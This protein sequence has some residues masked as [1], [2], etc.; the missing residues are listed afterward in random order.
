MKKLVCLTMAILMLLGMMAGCGNNA[1]TTTTPPAT[2]PPATPPPTDAP[3][4]PPATEEPTPTVANPADKF[5]DKNLN[6]AIFKGGFGDAYWNDM[7]AQFEAAYPGVKVNMT[8]DADIGNLLAPQIAVGEWPDFI[9]LNDTER[10]GVVASMVKNKQLLDLTDVFN[11][12]ALDKPGTKLSDTIMPGILDSTKCAV[13]GDGKI[14]IAPF[15]CSP[16][17]LV[18]NKALFA[19]KGWKVPSTWDEFFALNEELKKPE[20]FV[21]VDGKQVQRA[22]LTYQGIYAGY[23]ESFFWPAVA[24]AA[25]M[26]ALKNIGAYKEGSMTNP[27]VMKV[28]E[29]FAKIGTGYLM[30]GTTALDHTQSQTDMML[31]KALFIPD[32][33]WLEGEMKDAP[34][35]AGLE[36]G[37]MPAPVLTAGQEH[38][39]LSS[40]EQFEIPKDAKNPELAK[41]FLRFLYTKASVE[42]F[43]KNSG[44]STMATTDAVDIA[45]PFQ[46]AV[47][48]GMYTAYETGMFMLMNFDPLPADSKV[49]VS[50][51]VFDDNI[52][53]MITGKMSPADY[54]GKIEAAFAQIRSDAQ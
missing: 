51:T 34:R 12:E 53:S 16:M 52:G 2:T 9:S 35:E 23:L 38:Y 47:T 21:E 30:E 13:Y 5:A 26:D 43:A 6:I 45:K 22:V 15:N 14:Y 20:N 31:G 44:G 46:S 10:S 36:F 32:G 1:Q 28:I 11:G 50:A 29:Q 54:A 37:I 4:T 49:N 8:I 27:D 33:T 17:G 39:V 42:S 41:E 48:A 7:V 3:T 25:G 24:S 40:L 19:A 18:Y